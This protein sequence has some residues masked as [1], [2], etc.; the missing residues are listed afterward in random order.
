MVLETNTIKMLDTVAG[1]LEARPDYATITFQFADASQSI[2]ALNAVQTYDGFKQ[3]IL[4]QQAHGTPIS[5]LS[6]NEVIAITNAI[7]TSNLAMQQ[8]GQLST[9]RTI[10]PKVAEKNNVALKELLSDLTQ[11]KATQQ[12]GAISASPAQQKYGPKGT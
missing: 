3:D 12:S 8:M 10:A 11:M 5:V 6:I 1:D 4:L 9:D 7:I 2:S